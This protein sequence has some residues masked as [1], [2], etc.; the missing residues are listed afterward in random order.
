MENKEWEI[1][2]IHDT[3]FGARDRDM[4]NSILF[5]THFPPLEEMI[6]IASVGITVIYF[7]GKI[8]DIK[9]V[10]FVNSMTDSK[11]PLEIINLK[12]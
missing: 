5:S 7:F 2:A 6:L 11:I 8:T 3:L 4:T 9:T 10:E 1:S 12:I